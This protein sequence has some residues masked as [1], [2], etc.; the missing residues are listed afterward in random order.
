MFSIF[1]KGKFLKLKKVFSAGMK[2]KI[3]II[4]VIFIHSKLIPFIDLKTN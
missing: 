4:S 1:K 3:L 2:E